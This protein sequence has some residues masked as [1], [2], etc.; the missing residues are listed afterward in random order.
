MRSR[1]KAAL[2]LTIG[3]GSVVLAGLPPERSATASP[4]SAREARSLEDYR[5]Y[6]ALHIDL[7]GRFPTREELVIFEGADFDESAWVESHLTGPA[8]ADRLTRVYMD[9][10]RLEV[11][12]AVTVTPQATT[13]RR[14][15]ILGPDGKATYVYYRRGQRRKRE[16][17]DGE[18]C[19]TEAETGLELS[20][21]QPPKGTPIPVKV[22]TLEEATVL[23]KPWWLYKDYA[24]SDP[25]A[26][27]GVAWPDVD[28]AFVPGDKL[29]KEPDGTLTTSVRICRE[30]AHTA[31]RGTVYASGRVPPPKGAPL[32]EG[33]KR[34][35]PLDDKYAKEH[36]GQSLS[37][38]NALAV[39]ASVDCGCGVGLEHC[40]P[41][42][43]DAN[44]PGAFVIPTHLPLGPT[45]P[46]PSTVQNVSTYSKLLWTE[47]ALRFFGRIFEQDRDFREVLTGSATQVNGPLAQFYRSTSRARCCSR[48][49]PFGLDEERTPLF[50]PERVPEGL[51]PSE[52]SHW[53]LVPDRGP[54]S[55]GLLTMPAFLEKFASRRARAA[56]IYT[57]F[58]C[59]SF[60]STAK[61]LAP[62]TEPNLMIRPGCA[63]CHATLEPLAAYFSRV[64]ETSTV[65]LPAKELPVDDPRCKL[66]AKGKAPG[67]CA[68]FYDPAFST[69]KAGKL[70][71]A[72]A[73]PANAE[74]GPRGL[75]QK[76]VASP[77]FARCA[78]Q[79]VAQSFLGRPLST[80][81]DALV[82]TLTES[83]VTSGY[84]MRRLVSGIV[85]SDAY[86]RANNRRSED[87]SP[88]LPTPGDVPRDDIHGGAR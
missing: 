45:L 22:R 8:F 5:R 88:L 60:S 85:R 51:A 33:R 67:F 24:A 55:A 10:L 37:C 64:E 71:G 57:T 82:T 63:G 79:R 53:M 41:G 50:D 15:Q 46:L 28:P 32:P 30:E 69:T 43:S 14:I 49:R 36:A 78:V 59:K 13:L 9:P 74:S 21:N 81:D 1:T 66:D 56:A 6:R 18:L 54:D 17:T 40:L 44:D 87:A 38:R 86:R 61:E 65:Y 25:K 12:N 68:P 3:V 26:R 11:G 34:P 62:S 23:V 7:V 31:Q 58:T 72:Y 70:R 75:G 39:T 48:E 42:D 29:S 16:S 47:E 84:R 19:L 2:A 52:M 35:A 76:L 73:S 77:E 80:D 83:F 20:P 27:L 4:H